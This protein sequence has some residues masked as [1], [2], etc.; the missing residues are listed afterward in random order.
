MPK[1]T[2]CPHSNTVIVVLDAFA[3]VEV[4]GHKCEACGE[5][6]KIIKN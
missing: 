3:M 5:I 2:N 4:I 6:V 1:P